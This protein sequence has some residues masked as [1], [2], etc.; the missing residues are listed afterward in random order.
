M[1]KQNLKLENDKSRLSSQ[2]NQ[3]LGK[4]KDL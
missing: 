3:M 4:F 1:E 2:L